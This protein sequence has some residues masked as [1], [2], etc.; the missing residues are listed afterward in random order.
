MSSK[1]IQFMKI[2]KVHNRYTQLAHIKRK[3]IAYNFKN[4]NVSKTLY[5][6]NKTIVLDVSFTKNGKFNKRVNKLKNY[7]INHV[8][9]SN[10]DKGAT[11]EIIKNNYVNK[12]VETETENTLS[13]EIHPE[14]K[15]S[16]VNEHDC[17]TD[18]EYKNLS[19][20]DTIDVIISFKGI[21]YGKSNFT[22]CYIIHEIKR[23]YEE[24][25][26]LEDCH[27][28]EDSEEEDIDNDY[29]KYSK[30]LKTRFS[31]F[32]EVL[33]IK[34]KKVVEEKVVEEKVVEEK[35]EDVVKNTLQNIINNI[36]Q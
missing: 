32:Y 19:V 26:N 24:K 27:I 22:N 5:R 34:N 2:K 16:K 35:V 21:I 30:K 12:V 9:E 28:S 33:P 3:K 1:D 14:C 15:F 25:I 4:L 10:K 23:H 6:K 8:F 13:I 7:T 36:T 18:D 17:E 11:I 29:D 20:D 31:N